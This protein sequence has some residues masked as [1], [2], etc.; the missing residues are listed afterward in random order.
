M[1]HKMWVQGDLQRA[2]I[3][4]GRARGNRH[5]M[6]KI[7]TDLDE[8]SIRDRNN[9][10][11]AIAGNGATGDEKPGDGGRLFSRVSKGKVS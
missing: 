3:N 9:N 7:V 1:Q 6:K 10:S 4:Q 11:G 8:I 2:E 5:A